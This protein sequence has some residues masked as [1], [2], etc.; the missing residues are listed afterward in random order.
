IFRKNT[1]VSLAATD[2]QEI[3]PL[4]EILEKSEGAILVLLRLKDASGRNIS[5][6]TYWISQN[7][8]YRELNKMPSADLA[9]TVVNSVRL[10]ATR[11]WTLRITNPSDKLAF[12]IRPQLM[13]NGEEVLPSFW[14]GNY[15]TLAPSETVTVKVS[16]PEEKISKGIPSLRISG[17][18]V[19]PQ[20]INLK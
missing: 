9:V 1:I 6:N 15:F 19:G 14:S 16:C 20:V 7:G 13:M 12:F 8:D 5:S 11:E 4:A 2:V 10:K 3:I 18:N 17:W